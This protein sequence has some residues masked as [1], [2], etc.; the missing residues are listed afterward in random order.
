MSEFSFPLR[1]HRFP[2]LWP[3]AVLC[4]GISLTIGWAAFLGWLL[5][6]TLYGLW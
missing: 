1:R 3:I 2:N 4:C 6:V 5:V